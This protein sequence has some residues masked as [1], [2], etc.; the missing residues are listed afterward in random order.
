MNA[1]KPT[2][3]LLYSTP[4]L[5]LWRGVLVPYARKVGVQYYESPWPLLAPAADR[6]QR[7]SDV[8]HSL[9][10]HYFHGQHPRLH[11]RPTSLASGYWIQQPPNYNQSCVQIG[12][13]RLMLDTYHIL[14]RLTPSAYKHKLHEPLVLHVPVTSW[15]YILYRF[16]IGV[17]DEPFHITAN[18]V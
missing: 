6:D 1:T 12:W 15:L 3:T 9:A 14:L 18:I 7:E 10:F 16:R 4:V 13:I 17:E 11:E 5:I 8:G 2:C